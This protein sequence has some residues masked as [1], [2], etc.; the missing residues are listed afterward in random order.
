[1]GS[2]ARL[3]PHRHQE[4]TAS[5]GMVVFLASWAMMFAGLF[6]AYGFIRSSAGPWP[7]A[8]VPAL[9]VGL[10]AV[11]TAVLLSSSLTFAY[12]LRSLRRG[13]RSVFIRALAVT[14]LLGA[15]FL[16]LQ[17]H[18]WRSVGQSG[19]H[20]SSGLYGSVFYAL[21]TFHALHVAVGL[22]ILLYV[23]LR[24]LRGGYTEHN[25]ITVRLCTMFWHFVD[26]VWILMFVTIYLL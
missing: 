4:Q 19:L 21:T 18:V 8:G 24:A 1:M 2:V 11:N 15:V 7:P 20:L 16:A 3:L 10:P 23:L 5:V 22:L 6:F 17:I 26:V 25:T 12:G 13:E 9:P 14:I